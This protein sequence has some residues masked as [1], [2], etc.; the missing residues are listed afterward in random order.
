MVIIS[1]ILTYLEI[2][3]ES[4][5]ESERLSALYWKSNQN[6]TAGHISSIDPN[7]QSFK[8]ALI[9]IAFAAAYLEA[10]LHIEGY[11]R[12]GAEVY[13]KIDRQTYRM[14]MEALGIDDSVLLEASD[15]FR[16]ARKDLFHEK[17]IKESRDPNSVMRIAQSEARSAIEF[18]KSVSNHFQSHA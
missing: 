6:G 5:A 4:L 11:R 12:L 18:V 13:E 2:A 3:T 7:Q 15:H 1:N 9:A 17:P 14:K 16:A 10:L 8:H